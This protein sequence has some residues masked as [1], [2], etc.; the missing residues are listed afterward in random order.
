[1]NTAHAR[2]LMPDYLRLIALFG[3]VIVNVQFIA[4]PNLNSITGPAGET[5][6]DAVA[7][8]LVNGLALLKTYGL[9]S[10]MFGAGVGF[11]MRSSERLGLPSAAFIATE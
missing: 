6:K 8:W 2:A 10:F 7:L 1:M 5:F 9:F 4:F 11:L 3:I